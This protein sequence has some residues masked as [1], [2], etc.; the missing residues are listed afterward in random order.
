MGNGT[1]INHALYKVLT[2]RSI[3][4]VLVLENAQ[5]VVGVYVSK[6]PIGG[7]EFPETRS[8][9]LLNHAYKQARLN[10]EAILEMKRRYDYIADNEG[11][12]RH[13]KRTEFT[14]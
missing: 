7:V 1:L 6:E 13:D 3:A 2:D 11:V 4:C 8:P 12:M 14:G 9:E 5:E 10:A